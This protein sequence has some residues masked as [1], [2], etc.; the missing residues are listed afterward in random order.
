MVASDFVS[1]N[2]HTLKIDGHKHIQ[3]KK[4]VHDGQRSNQNTI[5][6]KHR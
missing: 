3:L 1:H 5:D 6:S 4:G 2:V